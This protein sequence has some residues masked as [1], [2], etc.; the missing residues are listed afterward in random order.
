MAQRDPT[1]PK[2]T[3]LKYPNRMEDQV[4]NDVTMRCSIDDVIDQLK[5]TL[6]AGM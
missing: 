4:R 5:Q 1:C 6:H 3:C 2:Q